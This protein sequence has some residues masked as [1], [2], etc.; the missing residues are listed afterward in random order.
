MLAAV[1]TGSRSAEY[2]LEKADIALGVCE[3]VSRHHGVELLQ[4]LITGRTALRLQLVMTNDFEEA[5]SLRKKWKGNI[6][7]S[8]IEEAEVLKARLHP[9]YFFTQLITVAV[10]IYLYHSKH[11][12]IFLRW[13]IHFS[14]VEM[15]EPVSLTFL[16]YPFIVRSANFEDLNAR[17]LDELSQFC[18][19]RCQCRHLPQGL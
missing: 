1:V 5:E 13:Q 6:V 2:Y 12:S 18:F 9:M 8:L 11:T 17:I 14:S 15:L 10:L 3:L 7:C 19:R 16:S 4:T